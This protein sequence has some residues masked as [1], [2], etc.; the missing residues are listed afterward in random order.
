MHMQVCVW[1][2]PAAYG[3]AGAA[4]PLYPVTVCKHACQTPESFA[5]HLQ[6][7]VWLVPAADGDAGADS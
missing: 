7:C 5:M 6:V 1:L 4:A 2:V 3:D